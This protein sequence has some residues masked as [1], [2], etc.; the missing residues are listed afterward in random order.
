MHKNIII[1]MQEHFN[2]K[3]IFSKKFSICI[4]IYKYVYFYKKYVYIAYFFV[5]LLLDIRKKIIKKQ[6]NN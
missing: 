4:N 1:Y 2:H 5:K 3:Y 6:K